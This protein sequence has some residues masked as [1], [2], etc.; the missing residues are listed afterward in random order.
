MLKKWG[1]L[2]HFSD[3]GLFWKQYSINWKGKLKKQTKNL[4]MTILYEE[5]K[6]VVSILEK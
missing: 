1:L 6:Y 5:I 4:V 2:T 3:T